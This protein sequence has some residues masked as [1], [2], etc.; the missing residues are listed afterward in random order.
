MH[1]YLSK[2]YYTYV[3]HSM[4]LVSNYRYARCQPWNGKLKM[5]NILIVFFF[6]T[7]TK[8]AKKWA[9]SIKRKTKY[10]DDSLRMSHDVI[11]P[12]R[13]SSFRSIPYWLGFSFWRIG[14]L[15]LWRLIGTSVF[16]SNFRPI[17]M[18]RYPFGRKYNPRLNSCINI[19]RV[20]Y[21]RSQQWL[22]KYLSGSNEP[23][24]NSDWDSGEISHSRAVLLKS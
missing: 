19:K 8:A 18:N 2:K 22:Q 6:F 4:T 21:S 12:W 17:T 9:G 23:H 11:T 10:W 5:E 1:N 7:G 16:P 24:K 13:R 20:L 15:W 14:C 3:W